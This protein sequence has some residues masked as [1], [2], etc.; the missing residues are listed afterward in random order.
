MV[1]IALDTA[2][3]EDER[4]S[5]LD[6]VVDGAVDA[7]IGLD[8]SHGKLELVL[9]GD[10][11]KIYSRLKTRKIYRRAVGRTDNPTEF[12]I[13]GVKFRIQ[14]ASHIEK[15]AIG[16][17]NTGQG[18]GSANGIIN[19]ATIDQSRM[20][21]STYQA[22]EWARRG[23]DEQ[24]RKEHDDWADTFVSPVN[25]KYSVEAIA[26]L[27]VSNDD[28]REN[29]F[30]EMF[31]E[32]PSK[33]PIA[34]FFPSLGS[35]DVLLMDVGSFPK[36]NQRQLAYFA[37]IG[38]EYAQN[39]MG[40]KNPKVGVLN[41]GT[42]DKKGPVFVQRV[43]ELLK[44]RAKESNEKDRINYVGYVEPEGIFIDRKADVVVVDGYAGN[45]GLKFTESL[46][47]AF[48]ELAEREFGDL[49]GKMKSKKDPRVQ[50]FKVVN[51]LMLALLFPKKAYDAVKAYRRI[52]KKYDPDSYGCTHVL[53]IDP[54]VYLTHASLS[55]KGAEHSIYRV[56]S[57]YHKL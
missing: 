55:R 15:I 5:C 2:G 48:R 37:R 53:G 9:F 16:T 3:N 46:F 47:N 11:E 12:M 20:L 13:S 35:E 40:I 4:S 44:K 25:T 22:T 28:E 31:Q 26:N 51:G 54:T 21:T 43:H 36:A 42:E 29:Y 34:A 57:D 52:R 50:A 39:R 38:Q 41:M 24:Y 33:K 27:L 10:E 8:L 6:N 56:L 19:G 18:L 30:R 17:E 32:D 45:L 49:I 7:A 1:R 23:K 14:D